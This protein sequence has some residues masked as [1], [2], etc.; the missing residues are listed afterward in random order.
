MTNHKMTAVMLFATMSAFSI[1]AMAADKTAAKK[2][3]KSS[4][5]PAAEPMPSV[6]EGMRLFSD[7]A[8]G[9]LNNQKSCNSCHPSGKGL[10]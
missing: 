1:H 6:E 9:G 4:R 7:P 3:L 10:E 2:S 5:T 8:L